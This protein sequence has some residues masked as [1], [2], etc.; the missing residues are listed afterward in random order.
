MEKSEKQNVENVNKQLNNREEVSEEQTFE[1]KD[2]N[3]RM[4]DWKE[5]ML[6]VIPFLSHFL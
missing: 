5:N 3:M 4:N 1:L 6:H 2:P